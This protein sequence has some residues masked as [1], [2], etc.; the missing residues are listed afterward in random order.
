MLPEHINNIFDRFYRVEPGIARH[1]GGT[2]LGLSICKTIIESHDGSIWVQS[3][4]G[5]GSKFS[6]SLPIAWDSGV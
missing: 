3:Q 4:L 5:E 2:G 1:R 6:F